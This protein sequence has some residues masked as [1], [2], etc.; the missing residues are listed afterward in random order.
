MSK[1]CFPACICEWV[2]WYLLANFIC[3]FVFFNFNFH[4]DNYLHF[5]VKKVQRQL[6]PF[7]LIVS[8]TSRNA[9][10]ILGNIRCSTSSSIVLDG[11]LEGRDVFEGTQEQNHGVLLVLDGS[12]V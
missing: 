12:H 8:S 1:L 10:I 4:S 5:V 9:F 3:F 11:L 6:F 7:L 2:L